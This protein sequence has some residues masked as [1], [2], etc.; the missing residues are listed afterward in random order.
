MQLQVKKV[1]G[2]DFVCLES[3]GNRESEISG[4]SLYLEK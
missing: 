3:F 4:I 1:A 2:K